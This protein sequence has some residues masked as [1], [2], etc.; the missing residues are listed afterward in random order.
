HV[1]AVLPAEQFV[2]GEAGGR[3]PLEVFRRQVAGDRLPVPGE[4]GRAGGVAVAER[5]RLGNLGLREPGLVP[6]VGLPGAVR[7]L[8]MQH[9]EE[10]PVGGPRL[11]ELDAE[12]GT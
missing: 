4:R 6:L 12:V 11:Q 1:A 9:E 3:L 2:A 7:G 5:G 8:V 10:R